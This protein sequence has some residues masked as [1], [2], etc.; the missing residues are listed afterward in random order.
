MHTKQIKPSPLAVLGA[1][2]WGTALALSLARGGQRIHLWDHKHT[3]LETMEK[4]RQNRYLPE[5]V[6]PDSII[7][8]QTLNQA[9]EGVQNILLVVPSHAFRK[10]LINLKP[11]LKPEHR[12][13]WATKGL[14]AD[15]GLFL[16]QIVEQE[17]GGD[18]ACSI[19]YAVL[20]GP[21]FANEVA[22]GLPTS[23]AIASKN[24]AFRE[25]ISEIFRHDTFSIAATD[26]IVGVQLG[27]V[28]KNVLAV[29]VGISDGVQF[30]A[31]TRAALITR[32]VSEMMHLG[33][34]LGARAETLMGLA[35]LGD[36]ILTCTDN[37]SRNRR[38]GLALGQGLTK[39]QALEQIGQVVEAVNNVE[40]LI[41]LAKKNGVALPITEQV[42]R[43]IK[44]GAPREAIIAL[45]KT[46]TYK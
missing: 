27:G 13:I 16:H 12:I 41:Q 40:Q 38:F 21:S 46:G 33:E 9:L 20:S 36:V 7:I 15:T 19:P 43:V 10:A 8:C 31:N 39:A 25:D 24:A 18:K 23:V 26:D 34:K 5:A 11:F 1:G 29:A 17:L 42:F 14:D 35:G 2:A 45:F 6:L 32:G 4:T 30:G 37:Q 44:H 28:V 3:L 22:Q